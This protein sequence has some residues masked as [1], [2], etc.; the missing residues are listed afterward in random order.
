VSEEPTVPAD[1]RAAARQVLLDGWQP[2]GYTV[3]NT[4]VYPFQWL[5]DSCFHAIV[6]ADLGEADRA[7]RELHHLFR[8]QDADGFVPHVDY[9]AAPD[10]HATF[11]GR[12][13]AS[14]ITQP[15]MYGHALAELHRRGVDVDPALCER[16][17]RGLAFLLDRR[18]RDT[19]TG[20]VTIVHPWESGADDS[21][22]WDD[23]RDPDAVDA[24]VSWFDM[25]GRLLDTVTRS[26]TG[27]PLAN[28]AFGAAPVAF[29]ALVA[30]NAMELTTL[31]DDPALAAAAADLARAVAA[32][33]D[34]TRRTWTDGGPAA[35]G[36]GSVRVLDALLGALVD[37]VHAPTALADAIDDAAYGG[38]C[39]PAGVHRAEA[40]FA[41]TSYWRGP[42]W[43]QLTYLL[44]VAAR[45]GAD[46]AAADALAAA[47]VEGGRR[48][49]FA[50]YW[51][52]D[53]GAPLGARP[54]S[55]ATLAAL[56]NPER[57]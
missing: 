6:W 47:L 15:P 51:H 34:D 21:P 4:A 24:A 12:R 10:T 2:A 8:T 56:V 54:Q 5:W 22:R 38:R 40:S 42:A 19:D 1:L 28:P 25:K 53:T 27:A 7:Q 13:G 18:A 16:A 35:T 32:R 11:W 26:A 23:W 29:S 43:P 50:E 52:P 36:S 30:F 31:V 3:P 49:G 39:G 57:G 37:P 48:S 33:W 44:W 17:R 9:E 20:L 55:W 45:R 41:P 14:S 46:L